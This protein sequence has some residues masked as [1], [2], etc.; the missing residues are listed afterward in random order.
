MECALKLAEEKGLLK[1]K[2]KLEELLQQIKTPYAY[3]AYIP[4]NKL[5]DM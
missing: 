3:S 2:A 1:A 5:K 4:P